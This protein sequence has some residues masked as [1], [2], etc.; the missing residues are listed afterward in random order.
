MST[1]NFAQKAKKIPEKALSNIETIIK[2]ENVNT[3]SSPFF[4]HFF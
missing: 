2:N 4:C 3:S 1:P